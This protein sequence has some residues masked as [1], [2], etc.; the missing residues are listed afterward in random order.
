MVL[1]WCYICLL[2]LLG[3]RWCYSWLHSNPICWCYGSLSHESYFSSFGRTSESFFGD[4]HMAQ[5]FS[6]YYW[7]LCSLCSG[8]AFMLWLY[9]F[10]LFLGCVWFS[11][12]NQIHCK[13]SGVSTKWVQ[14]RNRFI[15]QIPV[16]HVTSCHS[17]IKSI[18]DSCFNQTIFSFSTIINSQQLSH[19]SQLESDFQDS[20][21]E[22]LNQTNP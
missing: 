18:V 6:V 15:F 13:K 8:L 20:I 11:F 1:F 14:Q 5:E 12:L 2:Y 4:L 7:D 16:I 21:A 22:R 3:L 19:S 10:W 17:L 9:M